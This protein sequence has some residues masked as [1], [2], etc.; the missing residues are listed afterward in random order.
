MLNALK[1]VFFGIGVWVTVV[2]VF[3]GIWVFLKERG[4]RR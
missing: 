1:W 4:F 3:A 2:F